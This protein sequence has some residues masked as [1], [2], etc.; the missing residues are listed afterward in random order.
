[1]E[2]TP[3]PDTPRPEPRAEFR[4]QA[5]FQ[6]SSDPLF[7]LNHQRRILFVNRAWEE[8]TGLTFA[9][10]RGSACTRRKPVIPSPAQAVTRKLYPPAEVLQGKAASVRRLGP[11][12]DAR[13]DVAFLPFN[14]QDGLLCILGRISTTPAPESGTVSLLD[15]LE[16][17]RVAHGRRYR[18]ENVESNVPAVTRAVTQARLAAQTQ[19][20]VLILGEPGTGKRW[21]ARAIHEL[22]PRKEKAFAALDCGRLPAE[23]VEQALFGDAGLISSGLAGTVY[24]GEPGSLSRDL[25]ARLAEVL[26]EP[27]PTRVIAGSVSDLTT[28]VRSLRV[29][30]EF[31]CRLS[32]LVIELPPL[33]ERLVDLTALAEAFLMRVAD[34]TPVELTREAWDLLRS[35]SWPGNLEELFAVLVKARS[36]AVAGRVGPNELPAS[37]RRAAGLDQ[38]PRPRDEALPLETILEEA[39]RRLIQMALQRAG[40]NKTRAAELLGLWKPRL[41]RRMAALGL[42]DS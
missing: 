42:Q 27:P 15:N 28:E 8:L 24:L 17:L 21:W 40:G 2:P 14:D 35:Y 38:T 25:Q 16:A 4:W 6:R 19:A 12:T 33:R 36:R 34:P 1:M 18:L 9:D 31:R 23:A 39:E 20:A 13:W 22:G 7:V 11:A 26:A 5:F 30:E 37:L 29:L 3:A 41:L 32:T 10:V